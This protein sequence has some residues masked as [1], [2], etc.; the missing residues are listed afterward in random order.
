[1]GGYLLSSYFHMRRDNE[2][3]WLER[4]KKLN[5]LDKY[6]DEKRIELKVTSTFHK[7][8]HRE[9]LEELLELKKMPESYLKKYD[10]IY[11]AVIL[12]NY[13]D[14]FK[15]IQSSVKSLL[16]SNFPT[17]K[18]IV[19]IA[20][21]E[22]EVGNDKFERVEKIIKEF[23][24]DFYDIFYT[25]HPDGI[26]GEMKGKSAN[27]KWAGLRLREYIDEKKINHDDV[28]VSVFDGD[29]RVSKQYVACMIYKYLV[30]TKR[31]KRS[32]QPIPLF[33]NN[34]WEVSFLTRTVALGSSY[35][36][37]IESCRPYRLI[38]FSSQALSLQSLIDIDFQDEKIV[39]EDSR[40]FYRMFF[41]YRG[42][43]VAVPLFTPVY[44]DAVVGSNLWG[45][46]KNQYFQKRRWAWGMENFPYLVT[47]SMKHK[48]ISFWNKFVLIFRLFKGTVEWSTSSLLIAFAGWMPIILNSDF[49]ESV[50]AY[51][52][53]ILA[54]NILKITWVGIIISGAI[55]F[56]LLPPKPKRFSNWK[57][58]EMVFQWIVS[59]ITGVVFGSIPAIDAQTRF[60]LG[61]KYRL[62][63]WV[64]PKKFEER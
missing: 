7:N 60:I 63:F 22:R 19:V 38:N 12:P 36:Q 58:C 18:T 14:E 4:C 48:E 6:I 27:T 9:E 16:D 64:T 50:L 1:M 42:D 45:T 30:N 17:E 31:T 29:T 32:Y 10:N 55:G 53:P 54:S 52:L 28:M 11:H 40:Q 61:G 59:P 3:D 49:R 62:G 21:E 20:L 46:I 33:N 43:H 2:I 51:N 34:I 44:M 26:I 56:L 5:N 35:W 47:E 24:K 13:G 25:V 57:Y 23:K 15:I 39:S 37:M 8:R 41:K